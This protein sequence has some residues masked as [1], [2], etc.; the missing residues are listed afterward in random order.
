MWVGHI[1]DWAI[2][3]AVIILATSLG[4]AL[5]GYFRAHTG[6]I[7][8]GTP[9]EPDVARLS[10]VLDDVQKRVGELE[11]RLDFAE[12]L[13]AKHRDGERLARPGA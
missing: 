13:L 9:A 8:G 12:R 6:P 7:T 3:V 1:P 11:E 4:R 5:R 10:E 2:G